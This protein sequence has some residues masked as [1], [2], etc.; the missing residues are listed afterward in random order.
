MRSVQ[1]L[2]FKKDLARGPTHRSRRSEGLQPR[3][4]DGGKTESVYRPLV[5]RTKPSLQLQS[6]S[7]LPHRGGRMLRVTLLTPQSFGALPLRLGATMRPTASGR[8]TSNLFS[9]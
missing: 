5:G 8:L 9:L 1:S 6:Q 3:T 4:T 2:L 7:D